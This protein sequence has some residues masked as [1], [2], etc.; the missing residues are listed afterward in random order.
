MSTSPPPVLPDSLLTRAQVAELLAVSVT[1]VRRLG[2]DGSL[3]IAR[4][5]NSVRIRTSDLHHF[6]AQK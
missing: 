5:G 3:P 6:I 2:Y 4:V 1:T